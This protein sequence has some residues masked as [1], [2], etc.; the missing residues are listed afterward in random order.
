M[1]FRSWN[2]N[3]A[4]TVGTEFATPKPDR[5]YNYKWTNQWYRERCSPDVHTTP[6]RNDLDAARANLF[7]MHNR[8]HDW[9]YHLGFTEATWNMQ[10]DNLRPGGL[11]DDYEQGNAQAGGISGGPPN[12]EARNNANQIT[13][14]DGEAPITNMYLWQPIAAAFYGA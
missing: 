8:M 11:G 6:Q 1:L 12:F 13:P 4:F 14:P 5:D 7:G 9:S 10:D 3:D 2:S